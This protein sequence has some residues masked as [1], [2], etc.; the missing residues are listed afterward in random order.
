[1][2]LLSNAF[3]PG[4]RVYVAKYKV[5]GWRVRCAVTVAGFKATDEHKLISV[6]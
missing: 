6:V 2:K 4:Q 1:M 3:F 5:I